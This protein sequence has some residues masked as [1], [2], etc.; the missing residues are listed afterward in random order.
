MLRT[1]HNCSR[2]IKG[3]FPIFLNERISNKISRCYTGVLLNIRSKSMCVLVDVEYNLK[4]MCR[5]SMSNVNHAHPESSMTPLMI[6]AAR[7]HKEIVN[8]LISL[9]ADVRL[10]TAN[11]W[12]A[13]DWAVKNNATDAV[14]ALETQLPCE[15]IPVTSD[16]E[17]VEQRSSLLSDQKRKLCSYLSAHSES[18][19]DHKGI[20][21]IIVH[22]ISM[23]HVERVII[24]VPGIDDV[25]DILDF[26]ETSDIKEEIQETFSI[27]MLH[28]NYDQ[29]QFTDYLNAITNKKG[30]KLFFTVG[31]YEHSVML[32]NVE[33]VIDSGK[34]RTVVFD[35][36]NGRSQIEDCW[37]SQGS[38]DQRAS[39]AN[40]PN[41]ICYRMY[42]RARYESFRY[43]RVSE[44]TRKPLDNLC[45]W[46][47][48]LAPEG[49]SIDDY[50]S[51]AP[52]QPRPF[53]VK[54]AVTFLKALEALTH[55][56]ADIT[57][58]GFMMLNLPV[59]AKLA[60]LLLLGVAFRCLDP[61][62]TIASALVVQN[63][64]AKSNHKVTR[65]KILGK[66]NQF[67]QQ[68]FSDHSASLK[69]FLFWIKGR[70]KDGTSYAFDTGFL[71][72]GQCEMAYMVRAKILTHLERLE[73]FKTCCPQE[74]KE[75][76]Q[77][78]DNFSMIRAALCAAFFPNIL[79]VQ[80]EKKSILSFVDSIISIGRHSILHD[81]ISRKMKDTSSCSVP[82][83]W[84]IYSDSKKLTR[85]TEVSDLTC[86]SPLAVALFSGHTLIRCSY[87]TLAV[88]EHQTNSNS[89]NSSNWDRSSN[90]FLFRVVKWICFT[91]NKQDAELLLGL[92]Q[93]LH[94]LVMKQ[95]KIKAEFHLGDTETLSCTASLLREED[96]H[97]GLKLVSGCSQRSRS[98]QI[99]AIGNRPFFPSLR[100][101][102]RCDFC[103]LDSNGNTT[104][105]PSNKTQNVSCLKQSC[106]IKEQELFRRRLDEQ[107]AAEMKSKNA[108]SRSGLGVA[109][110]GAKRGCENQTS[111]LGHL[112]IPTCVSD[113][114]IPDQ[115]TRNLIAGHIG[116]YLPP[117]ML[118]NLPVSPYQPSN[119]LL[120][121]IRSNEYVNPY[122]DHH[123]IAKN[124][125]FTPLDFV[126]SSHQSSAT[127][128]TA[129]GKQQPSFSAASNGNMSTTVNL[130]CSNNTKC[131]TTV[132]ASTYVPPEMSLMT[133]ALDKDWNKPSSDSNPLCPNSNVN[134]LVP[135]TTKRQLNFLGK[136]AKHYSIPNTAGKPWNNSKAIEDMPWAKLE[137]SW[138][139]FSKTWRSD[140][141]PYCP[142]IDGD[143]MDLVKENLI[144]YPFE[145]YEGNSYA[146]EQDSVNIRS[147]LASTTERT[148][149]NLVS[150]V[151]CNQQQTY[152]AQKPMGPSALFSSYFTDEIF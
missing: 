64:I 152:H 67:A 12:T 34:D 121:C 81:V 118:S 120:H 130:T 23:R 36:L 88:P 20:A 11:G 132:T 123:Q 38:A 73:S 117:H 95:F 43:D 125:M 82:S 28:E 61:I 129:A 19:I 109:N 89:S 90:Q 39:L 59:E 53:S 45:L 110:G 55:E 27:I 135:S 75:Y 87:E 77:F 107:K 92:R 60:K 40:A 122:Y 62:L 91:T 105:D 98:V 44:I 70:E 127:A 69:A 146:G 119:Y 111:L 113:R 49:S 133:S 22:E 50:F 145:L 99:P 18:S 131:K 84:F 6:A 128:V 86:V 2:R 46:I 126:A 26:L 72:Y 85:K 101:R 24:F 14:A 78:S 7:N 100:N 151:R 147:Y 25:F 13:L 102:I 103:D 96:K 97:I 35:H 8:S 74:Y 66:K 54:V 93:R 56:T 31:T 15:S 42:T 79:R 71:N 114:S 65:A 51:L 83:N 17:I 104:S 33:V 37:I 116:R 52:E 76:N 9:G 1:L 68:S 4:M 10:C 136:D 139:G 3:I 141:K 142:W 58:L 112:P 32:A 47:R 106:L 80:W 144:N 57:E 134:L 140:S 108:Q 48:M 41:A 124:K 29:N 138:I 21:M 94:S 63:V 16:V 149:T 115:L 143:T 30:K 5:L 148:S 150:V 137:E